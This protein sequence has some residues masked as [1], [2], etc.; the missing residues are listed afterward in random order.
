MVFKLLKIITI[1]NNHESILMII[2]IFADRRWLPP[3]YGG[4]ALPPRDCSSEGT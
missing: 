1:K 2:F 3:S 4:R